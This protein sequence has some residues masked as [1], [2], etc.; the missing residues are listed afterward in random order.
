MEATK[1]LTVNSICKITKSN[2]M[3]GN[4]KYWEIYQGDALQ[5][6][7]LLPEDKFNC[8]I[9]SPPYYWLRD[10]KV[11]GQIGLEESVEGYVNNIADVMDEVLRVLS[12]DGILFL[13]L[14]DTYYSGKGKSHGIDKKSSKRRFG[15]R[16]VDKSGG[17]GI[18]LKQKTLI[19]VPWRVALE[20]IGR[21]WVLR[22]SII[23]YRKYAL[24]ESVQ[25]R[26][27]RSYENIFMFVKNREYYFN[28]QYLEDSEQEDMW[29]IVARAKAAN[30]LP[31]APF[32]DELVQR[33]L[34]I[35][36]PPEGAVLDPFAGSGTTLRVALQTGRSAVGIEIHQE[37]CKYMINDL[38]KLF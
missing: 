19:G 4:K 31:T 12:P 13:N 36:C 20:M 22:S 8:V 15:L 9:T 5:V 25:D 18:G 30:S 21:G 11:D 32:P 29:T 2:G 35:G 3:L 7:K 24:P 26:P 34:D 16:A 10:Y 1:Q 33:C 28:R 6:L 27:R 14:G 17:L 23:W 37:F 38:N